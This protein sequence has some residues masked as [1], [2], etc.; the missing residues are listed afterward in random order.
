[1]TSDSFARLYDFYVERVRGYMYFHV[2]DEHAADDLAARVFLKAWKNIH[3]YEAGNSP[4]AY[5][6]TA[7]PGTPC[8][9]SWQS[10]ARPRSVKEII[11]PADAGLELYGVFRPCADNGPP[12]SV[13]DD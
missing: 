5:G 8:W 2:P 9:I 3:C 1:M 4:S 10:I 11:S 12:D 7:S 6:S 13:V